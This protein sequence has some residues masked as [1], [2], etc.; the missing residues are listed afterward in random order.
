L[1]PIVGLSG[2]SGS[3]KSTAIEHLCEISAGERVYLGSFVLAE[4]AKRGLEHSREAERQVR[5]SMREQHG[6]GCLIVHAMETIRDHHQAGRPVFIDAIFCPEEFRLLVDEF[7][8]ASVKVL[9]LE[10]SFEIRASRLSIRPDRPF[11]RDELQRRDETEA[12]RLG[13]MSMFAD[14]W[15]TI[16]NEAEVSD[17][18]TALDAWWRATSSG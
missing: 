9:R 13:T 7:G 1:L 3:G 10:A 11:S 6:D 4:V 16:R 17:F 8:A 5:L 12:T 15:Y 2:H 14:A 18:Y